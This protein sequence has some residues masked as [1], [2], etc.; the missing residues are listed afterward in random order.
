MGVTIPTSTAARLI[1]DE[2]QSLFRHLATIPTHVELW[3]DGALPYVE[4]GGPADDLWAVLTEQHGINSMLAHKLCARK[5]P[6]LLPVY[7]Q[8]VKTAL[9]PTRDDYWVPLRATLQRYELVAVLEALRSRAA[10]DR[11]ISLLRVFD[12]AVWTRA[13]R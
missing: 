3:G 12:V 4:A 1:D 10:L 2:D 11:A 8:A 13:R 7:D 9:Q 5:R 6:H